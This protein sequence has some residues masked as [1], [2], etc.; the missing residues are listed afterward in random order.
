M[1]KH[2]LRWATLLSVPLIAWP[3]GS[4]ERALRF[5][6]QSFAPFS[7]EEAGQA[8]GPAVDIMQ[9]VC[10]S[11]GVRCLFS[12]MPWRR[13]VAE[14]QNGQADGLFPLLPSRDREKTLW[15]SAPLLSTAYGFFVPS[16]SRWRYRAPTDLA[17]MTLGVYGP[18]G[19]AS[20]LQEVVAQSRDVKTEVE[21]NNLTAFRKL[22]GGRYGD[23]AAVFANREVGL[24][25]LK[26]GALA[27]LKLAGELPAIHYVFALS[28]L[29]GSE[30]QMSR[31]NKAHDELQKTGKIQSILAR[32]GLE[33]ASL[34][35]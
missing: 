12:V 31:L 4:T 25:L 28:R 34:G 1:S 16:H 27:D 24:A 22:A 32:H 18:S 19:T 3:V 20:A 35:K 10:D 15:L 6:T 33:T 30:P 29:T 7:Y 14:V 13:A 8:A 17:G 26:Q 11:A 2:Y 9:A 5:V 23:Q 21:L